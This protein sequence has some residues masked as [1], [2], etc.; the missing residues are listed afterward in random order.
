MDI[1]L[2]D[3]HAMNGEAVAREH[4]AG[5]VAAAH[6]VY[7]DG[8]TQIFERNG[9]TSYAED[10]Q[11]TRGEWYVDNRGRFCSFW[12]PSFRACYRLHWLVEDGAIVGLTF[13][14]LSERSRFDERYCH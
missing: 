3:I 8:A 1:V 13:V 7:A 4:I 2:K 6:L 14:D 12:P 10:G 9:S 5:A 11:V